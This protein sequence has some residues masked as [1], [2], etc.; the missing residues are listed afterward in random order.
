MK[1]SVALNAYLRLMSRACRSFLCFCTSLKQSHA[2]FCKLRRYITCIHWKG[3]SSFRSLQ[4]SQRPSSIIELSV[5]PPIIVSSESDIGERYSSASIDVMKNLSVRDRGSS[6]D[7]VACSSL[8]V[9]FSVLT[10]RESS[11]EAP[12]A[13]TEAAG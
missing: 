7:G 10:I 12:D 6:F 2:I 4:S 3:S 5:E 1:V 11:F 13:K 8:S 9:F